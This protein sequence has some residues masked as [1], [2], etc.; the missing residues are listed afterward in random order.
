[1]PKSM[2]EKGM[3]HIRNLLEE[4][5]EVVPVCNLLDSEIPSVP[6]SCSRAAVGRTVKP[7]PR[8]VADSDCGKCCLNAI[9]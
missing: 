1:M 2:E 4:G 5:T 9:G 7:V 3:F 8:P 6:I